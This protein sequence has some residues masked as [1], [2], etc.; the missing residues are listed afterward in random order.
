MKREVEISLLKQAVD[1]IK[2]RTDELSELIR[3]YVDN[4]RKRGKQAGKQAEPGIKV[5]DKVLINDDQIHMEVCEVLRYE[6]VTSDDDLPYCVKVL[7]SGEIEDVGPFHPGTTVFQPLLS[8]PFDASRIP[9]D[10]IPGYM[11]WDSVRKAWRPIVRIGI[12]YDVYFE[13][14]KDDRWF[15]FRHDGCRREIDGV[16]GPYLHFQPPEQRIIKLA[17]E[18]DLIT[19]AEMKPGQIG[20]IIDDSIHSYTGY[21]VQKDPCC[22]DQV[23]IIDPDPRINRCW[24]DASLA[25]I[26]V[27]P[28]KIRITEVE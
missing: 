20:V 14:P 6:K 18:R 5:G 28:C 1:D 9:K 17:K 3:E 27:R 12:S 4:E 21:Y 15:I 7:S 19:F 11:V 26:K 22:K 23:N 16:H 25:D 10:K 13:K 2:L 8:G 24:S